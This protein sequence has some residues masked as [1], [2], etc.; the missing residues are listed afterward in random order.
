MGITAIIHTFNSEKYLEECLS[1]V[2]SCDEIIVCDMH[3]TDKT[4][5]I[6]QK[7]GAKIIYHENVG[8]ADPARNFALE[9]AQSDWILVVDSDEIIPD[10]LLKYL[11]EQITK[12]NCPDVFAIP[13]KNY[14]FGKWIKGAG[15]YPGQQVRF[16]R[17]GYA[18]WP[19]QVHCMPETKGIL[20][21]ISGERTDLAMIHYNYD[22]I[23]SFISRLNKYTSL[24]AE[25]YVLSGKKYSLFN[26]LFRP[27]WVF[28]RLYF[29]KKGY[30]DGIQGFFLCYM[31][32]FY[33]FSLLA[34]V[35]DNNRLKSG[36]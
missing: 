11:K 22:T 36:K 34:K 30:L 2:C 29:I 21:T 12:Q 26:L 13:R 14:M 20:L 23:E 18:W 10:K 6:A 31:M 4:I 16:F 19:P 32:A 5:E 35:W 1:S 24:E 7:F 15:W 8:Y 25:K 3:S 27:F 17:K 28:I 9:H 33:R